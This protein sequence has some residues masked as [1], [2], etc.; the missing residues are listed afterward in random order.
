MKEYKDI[1]AILTESKG[2]F[3]EM[4]E[5]GIIMEHLMSKLET[6]N[7]ILF[8]ET[9]DSLEDIAYDIPLDKAKHIVKTM[10]PFGEHWSYEMVKKYVE[11]KDVLGQCVYYYL[12]MNMMYN[13]YYDV[14]TNFGHQDDTEFYFELAHAFINDE[15]GKKHKVERYFM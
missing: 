7:P 1:M 8:K 14:A 13:D 12:V 15:D 2:D 3:K 4:K 11:N 5:Y 10:R 6:H 9:L